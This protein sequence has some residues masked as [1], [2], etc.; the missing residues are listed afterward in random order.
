MLTPA[1]FALGLTR[2]TLLAAA[3]PAASTPHTAPTDPRPEI[4]VL[5]RGADASA[6][7]CSASLVRSPRGNI[8]ATAA[9]CVAGKTTVNFAPGYRGG[10]TPFGVWESASI[11][12]DPRWDAA[13][14]ISGAGSPYDVAFVVLKP[15]AADGTLQNAADVT[16]GALSLTIDAHLPTAVRVYGYPSR[17]AIYQDALYGCAATAYIDADG[18]SWETL[19]CTGIPSGY[20]GG[21]WV[22]GERD[23]VGV[24]G[25]KGQSLPDTD[26]RNYSVRFGS[27]VRDLF[28]KAV[29]AAADAP[30]SGTRGYAL[31][32]G[33]LWK[34]AELIAAG[35]FTKTT[36]QMD[37]VVKWNDGEVTLYIGS[38]GDD[39]QR[40]FIGERQLAAPGGI[41]M[42]AKAITSAGQGLVVLWSD[43]EVSLYDDIGTRGLG[44]EHQLLPPNALWRDHASLM[45]C[46][47]TD[48]IVVWNDGEVSLYG[49]V[50]ANGLGAERQLIAPN[51]VWTHARSISAGSYLGSR[52]AADLLVV[53]SDGELS[54]YGQPSVNMLGQEH[55]VL[56]PNELW[57]HAT[58][59]AGYG[60]GILVRWVD[61]EVSLY[62]GVDGALH[63]EI[64]LVSP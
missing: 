53:W 56:P 11:L 37:M 62:P 64:Q 41:W 18:A 5:S 12:V 8:V 7:F 9:H 6:H 61:G 47:G 48:L 14:D 40:P 10:Q 55:Q 63:R 29:A 39:P 3:A 42:F 1:L 50:E 28:D 38:A 51:S 24:I 17:N 44:A 23:L 30:K 19:N 27:A 22:V 26:P 57:T 34:H 46:A 35:M 32:D 54:I 52:A 31:G 49:R 20:S 36:G 33:P 45:A 13:H 43:G 21:P 4:G 58:V 60:Q 2:L 59:A 25:G 16:G 15:R